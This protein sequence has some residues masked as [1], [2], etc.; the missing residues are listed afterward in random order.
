MFG[1]LLT[2]QI[3]LRVGPLLRLWTAKVEVA[4]YDSLSC[5]MPNKAQACRNIVPCGML[6]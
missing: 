6:L 4:R 3:A 2:I 5:I 1:I